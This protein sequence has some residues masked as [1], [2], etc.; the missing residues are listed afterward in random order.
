MI[1]KQIISFKYA[2]EGFYWVLKTQ[3]NFQIS[4]ILSILSL[5]FGWYFQVSYG[6]LLIILVLIFIGL[7]IE[8]I[9]TAIEETIDAL[10]K[11]RTE[12]IK[13]AKDVSAAAMFIFS[14]GAFIIACMI[15]LPR[16]SQLIILNFKF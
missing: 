16:I 14:I 7:A 6:E 12:E 2:L 15:F 13:I 3:R 1:K 8:T 4:V 11:D 9:N 5:G 10:H